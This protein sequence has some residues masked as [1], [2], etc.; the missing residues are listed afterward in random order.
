[1]KITFLCWD[2]DPHIFQTVAYAKSSVHAIDREG[3]DT[4]RKHFWE[5]REEWTDLFINGAACL[6]D[7]SVGGDAEF[8]LHVMYVE[9]INICTIQFIELH[10]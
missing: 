3:V 4:L 8:G 1:M 10:F 6:A 2:L 7:M 9:E 5:H